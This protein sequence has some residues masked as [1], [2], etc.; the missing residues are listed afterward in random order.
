MEQNIQDA[1]RQ[2]FALEER[3][4]GAQVIYEEGRVRSDLGRA[5]KGQPIKRGFPASLPKASRHHSTVP[6]GATHQGQSFVVGQA[7]KSVCQREPDQAAGDSSDFFAG[8]IWAMESVLR[9]KGKDE[10]G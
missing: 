9:E 5:R 1:I 7:T 2:L 3:L 6:H 10:R 8:L 4:V